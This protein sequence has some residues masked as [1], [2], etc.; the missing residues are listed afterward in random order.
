MTVVM[1]FISALLAAEPS[2]RVFSPLESVDPDQWIDVERECPREGAGSSGGDAAKICTVESVRQ[3]MKSGDP[4][5][6]LALLLDQADTVI[7]ACPSSVVERCVGNLLDE[8]YG[9]AEESKRTPGAS[10][11]LVGQCDRWSFQEPFAQNEPLVCPAAIAAQLL[12]GSYTAQRSVT[13][14]KL[15]TLNGIHEAGNCSGALAKNALPVYRIWGLQGALT[16]LLESMRQISSSRVDEARVESQ[17]NASRVGESVARFVGTALFA[18][19]PAEVPSLMR[20]GYSAGVLHAGASIVLAD[21]IIIETGGRAPALRKAAELSREGADPF[22]ALT[23]GPAEAL[24]ETIVQQYHHP[25]ERALRDPISW[26]GLHGWQQAAIAKYQPLLL[27][28]ASSPDIRPGWRGRAALLGDDLTALAWALGPAAVRP[29]LGDYIKTPTAGEPYVDWTQR[30]AFLSAAVGMPARCLLADYSPMLDRSSQPPFTRISPEDY[31][32]A[33]RV[34]DELRTRLVFPGGDAVSAELAVRRYFTWSGRDERAERLAEVPAYRNSSQAVRYRMLC[35]AAHRSDIDPSIPAALRL[36]ELL[37][38][39]QNRND[40][41]FCAAARSIDNAAQARSRG[42]WPPG[43][44]WVGQLNQRLYISISSQLASTAND[45]NRAAARFF[46]G[47]VQSWLLGDAPDPNW[48]DPKSG[49]YGV[50]SPDFPM[51]EAMDRCAEPSRTAGGA[52]GARG[53]AP[54]RGNRAS[55]S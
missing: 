8:F 22:V 46:G 1:L 42:Y 35:A 44:L 34:G 49:R 19:V 52:A 47:D 41:A 45:T 36:A 29:T 5:E 30:S 9:S 3:Y 50:W 27:L 15:G 2:G 54:T 18:M 7:K 31:Q 23:L 48:L 39:E 16:V 20:C 28:V 11:D 4:K 17:A 24:R 38:H 21:S 32:T 25:I 10:S 12:H 51:V 26:G 6:Q 40:V 43:E 13:N 33:G 37:S 14:T 53:Q 55:R